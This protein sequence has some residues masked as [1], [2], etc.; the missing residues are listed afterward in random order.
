VAGT[1]VAV[2]RTGVALCVDVAAS[3]GTSVLSGVAAAESSPSSSPPS[4]SNMTADRIT[5]ARIATP[6]MEMKRY[7]LHTELSLFLWLLID[8]RTGSS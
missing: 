1:D 3:C 7:R 8:V 2:G 4:D 6:A 5:A